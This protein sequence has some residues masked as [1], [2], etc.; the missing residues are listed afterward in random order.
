MSCR[1]TE[2]HEWVRLEREV[3]TVG[4]TDYAQGELGDIVYV[5]L[6]RLGAQLTAG[7]EACVLESTKSAADVY[8]P[9]S[10]QVVAINELLKEQV[11]LINSD[12]EGSGWLFQLR[13]SK[14]D[15]FDQLMDEASYRRM[16]R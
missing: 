2:T 7:S 8:A 1:F 13:L 3:A 6:P 4:I 16:V 10:G 14:P 15:E 5:E 12:A 9:V 11:E